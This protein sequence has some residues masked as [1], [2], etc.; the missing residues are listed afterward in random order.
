[1]QRRHFFASIIS[2]QKMGYWDSPVM[3]VIVVV[4]MTMLQETWLLDASPF[5]CYVYVNAC[6]KLQVLRYSELK[7][8]PKYFDVVI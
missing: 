6:V 5:A 8:I 2:Q 3:V 7:Q 1:M 4:A